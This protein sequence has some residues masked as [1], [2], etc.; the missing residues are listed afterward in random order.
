[1]NV[2]W[3]QSEF[4]EYTCQFLISQRKIHMDTIDVRG[5]G[6]DLVAIGRVKKAV[7]R[8]GE[9]FINRVFT[10]GERACCAVRRDPHPCYAARFAAKEAVLKS[11]GTGLSAGSRWRDIEVVRDGRGVPGVVLH[12]GAAAIAREKGIRRI[13]LT[14]S[15]DGDYA[16]A[17]AMALG[18]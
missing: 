11:L 10:P 6:T 2:G 17:F 16:V 8:F 15:H 13:L 18:D 12:G 1:M 5:I 14:L 9:R 7:A 3:H 4:T